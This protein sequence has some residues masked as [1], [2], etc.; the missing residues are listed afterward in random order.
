[1][2]TPP[3]KPP[4]KNKQRAKGRAPLN[5]LGNP[6]EPPQMV[7]AAVV[8]SIGLII[9]VSWLP[10][11][12]RM[13]LPYGD[14]DGFYIGLI[15]LPMIAMV[16]G[17][18]VS[19]LIDAKKAET[20]SQTTARITASR[21]EVIHHRFEGSETTVRNVPLVEYDFTV[22]GQK[23]RG[24]RI[25]I[26]E[27]PS[28]AN[29][30]ATLAKYKTGTTV[31]V[32]YDPRNPKDCV[33]ERDIPKGAVKGCAGFI[34]IVAGIIVAI[35]YLVTHASQFLEETLPNANAPLTVFATC[36]ALLVLLF[37]FGMR[38]MMK[39]AMNWPYV[40]GK[41]EVSTT[42]VY[43]EPVSNGPRRTMYAPV[44]EY[45]YTVNGVTYRSKQ[46]NVGVTSS[47][48]QAYAQKIAARYPEGSPV[49]VHYDPANP[50]SAA[51]ENPT[52]FSWLLLAVAAAC[53]GIAIY[54]SGVFK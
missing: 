31:T 53:F 3:A 5:K 22:N 12:W 43:R 47:G 41:I 14:H 54:T 30:E 8:G 25:S 34:A 19:K 48:S 38:H 42:E 2:A 51:L 23:W 27:D 37:F 45:S 21:V 39:R 49:E 7:I 20:W 17:A 44:V 40:T 24:N 50:S 15:F 33:L 18:I 10:D 11:S 1:M 28:G 26:G 4:Q 9:L 13:A 36:F 52:G 46:I 16:V 29:I 32:Y 6:N 35:Y